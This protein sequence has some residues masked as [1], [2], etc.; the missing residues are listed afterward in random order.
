MN[1]AVAP[2]GGVRPYEA[3]KRTRDMMSSRALL[4]RLRRLHYPHAPK[5]YKDRFLPALP[6]PDIAVEP[7][8]FSVDSFLALWGQDEIERGPITIHRVKIA[9]CKY[10]QVTHTDLISPR[11][12]A[13]IVLPRQVAMYL[14]RHLTVSSMP[15]IG[16]A[17][18]N[19]DHTTIIHADRKISHLLLWKKDVVMAVATIRQRLS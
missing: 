2:M 1:I 8:R 15:Q 6:L 7:S 10:F 5:E 19:R 4:L 17:F 9:T 3:D 16:R 12:H 18:G 11:K 13:S 14:C